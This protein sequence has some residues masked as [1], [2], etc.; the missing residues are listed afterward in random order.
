MNE[1]IIEWTQIFLKRIQERTLETHVAYD[2]GYKFESVNHFLAH[3]DIESENLV[4][5]LSEAIVNNNLVTA[6]MYFPRKMLLIYA[7]HYPEETREILR[8]LF[9]ESKDVYIRID[10][11]ETAFLNLEARQANEENRKPVSTYIGLRFISLLLGYRHPNKYNPLK[12]AEWRVFARFIDPDFKIPHH[13]S[14]GEQYRTYNKYIEPLRLH[15]EGRPEFNRIRIALTQG[16]HIQDTAFRWTTQ[17]VIFVTARYYAN[18]KSDQA[19]IEPALPEDEADEPTLVNDQDTGFMA[20]EKHLEEFVIKNWENIDFGN[21][22]KIYSDNEGNSG[23]QY[24]TDVG[25]MDILAT[26]ID[27]NYVVIEL[28]RAKEGYKVVGQT[29]NYIGWVKENLATNDEH[30]Y[31][32]IIV[33]EADKTL[34]SA[35]KP[36]ENILKIKE[37]HIQFSLTDGV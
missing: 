18:Q 31:G 24:T 10:D 25:I 26:D 15:I 9:D 13:T 32:L 20:L 6:A 21:D 7:E 30:V 5:N 11:T 16:L 27:G 37:Y 17:D 12:P 19:I 14:A 34:K 2:E 23:Q 28:K 29:L 1:K 22:L 4:A 3:F 8:N 36:V 35:V 33:G